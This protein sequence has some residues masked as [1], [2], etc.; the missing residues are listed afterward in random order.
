M[1]EKL[2]TENE[3]NEIKDLQKIFKI[4]QKIIKELM[5][6]NQEKDKKIEILIKE[7]EMIKET[8][9]T[10]LIKDSSFL[11]DQENDSSKKILIKNYD[12][13]FSK[14][15]RNSSF[16][17]KQKIKISDEEEQEKIFLHDP[18]QIFEKTPEKIIQTTSQIKLNLKRI[19]RKSIFLQDQIEFNSDDSLDLITINF[20]LENYI[21]LLNIDDFEIGKSKSNQYR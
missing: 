10:K 21:C 13:N 16:F 6:E 5:K 19:P 4:Y 17:S 14:T 15:K 8:H 1:K 2:T 3:L 7:N 18:E 11:I 20:T 9:S 12:L